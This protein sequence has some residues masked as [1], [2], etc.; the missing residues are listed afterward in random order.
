MN[1]DKPPVNRSRQPEE[2][3]P[4]RYEDEPKSPEKLYQQRLVEFYRDQ[5]RHGRPA[6]ELFGQGYFERGNSLPADEESKQYIR[7][8]YDGVDRNEP[9]RNRKQQEKTSAL[10]RSAI[11]KV[12]TEWESGK[13]TS[14]NLR[15]EYLAYQDA[16]LSDEV[17]AQTL[18]ATA[19]SE[20]AE[21]YESALRDIF[22][23]TS[24]EEIIEDAEKIKS[25]ALEILE[26]W[27]LA[28]S[29]YT[30]SRT[31]ALWDIA[32]QHYIFT[33]KQAGREL[34]FNTEKY[35]NA[36]WTDHDK[37]VE[38][39][40]R[41]LGWELYRHFQD[42][43]KQEFFDR[44][45][46]SSQGFAIGRLLEAEPKENGTLSS[47]DLAELGRLAGLALRKD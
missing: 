37:K 29:P 39:L 13:L 14:L 43:T 4:N 18:E 6:S 25:V 9:E 5:L 40:N 16:D 3:P 2:M 44:L 47:S 8:I 27:N 28:P 12:K 33:E 24:S 31:W 19:H 34:P 35:R 45:R 15:N 23:N 42:G 11:E 7:Q 22:S 30:K 38:I 41:H 46:V 36:D 10:V 17:K 20:S 26:S 32:K 1:I 21:R